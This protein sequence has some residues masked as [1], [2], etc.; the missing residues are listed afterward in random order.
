MCTL[1]RPFVVVLIEDKISVYW[2]IDIWLHGE[3]L[4]SSYLENCR[5]FHVEKYENSYSEK[6]GNKVDL[7]VKNKQNPLPCTVH[8]L[9]TVVLGST[10]CKWLFKKRLCLKIQKKIHNPCSGRKKEKYW[11]FWDLLPNVDWSIILY[12]QLKEEDMYKA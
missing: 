3:I 8:T 9:H 4:N 1:N 7:A 6:N 11:R 5:T 2:G 10:L 12:T